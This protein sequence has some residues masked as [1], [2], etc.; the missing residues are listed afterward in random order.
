MQGV[1]ILQKNLVPFLE[2]I[3]A[4]FRSLSLLRALKFPVARRLNIEKGVKPGIIPR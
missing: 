1:E 3:V 2:N 4:R